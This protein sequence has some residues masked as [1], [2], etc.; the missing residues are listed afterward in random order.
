M[1]NSFASTLMTVMVIAIALALPAGF[2]VI[3][4]N[5]SGVV[6][7]WE[8]GNQ[9]SVFLQQGTT[10]AQAMSLRQKILSQ[11]GVASVDYLSAQMA[12]DEFV[13]NSGFAEALAV[14]DSNPLPPLLVVQPEKRLGSPVQVDLLAR[15]MGAMEGVDFVQIDMEWIQRLHS[16]VMI[17]KRGVWM[18][19]L[20]LG[21]GVL[22]IVGNTIRLD[23]LNR[24]DEIVITKLVGATDRFVRRPFLCTGFWYGLL[25]GLLAWWMIETG[26]WVLSEP[27]QRLAETYQSQVSLHGPGF[28]GGIKLMGFSIVLSLCGAWLAVGRH[29]KKIHPS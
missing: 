13:E 25:G 24:R 19:S 3:L 20:L 5:L 26:L 23:I 2:Q 8:G 27:V 16:V 18:I 15:E 6:S 21:L 4:T 10:E 11:P 9:V 14:L 7:R 28:V 12:L 29:L 1:K 17:F 22:L